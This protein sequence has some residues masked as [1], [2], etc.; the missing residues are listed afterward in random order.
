M[1]ILYP[2]FIQIFFHRIIDLKLDDTTRFLN[3]LSTTKKLYLVCAFAFSLPTASMTLLTFLLNYECNELFCICNHHAIWS[4][5]TIEDV[6]ASGRFDIFKYMLQFRSKIT[7]YG[8]RSLSKDEFFLTIISFILKLC[9]EY[10]SEDST[11]CQFYI[12]TVDTYDVFTD[13]SN[14]N[15]ST[16]DMLF[17]LNCH[18]LILAIYQRSKILSLKI[19]IEMKCLEYDNHDLKTALKLHSKDN[20]CSLI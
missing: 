2:I 8:W 11:L 19:Y 12:Y 14:V 6:I 16:L 5:T 9:Q 10:P 18:H 13:K 15:V 20:C 17:R 7:Y 3:L 1:F 4:I